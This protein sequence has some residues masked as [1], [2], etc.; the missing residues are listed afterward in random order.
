VPNLLQ[1]YTLVAVAIVLEAH[2]RPNR[3]TTRASALVLC[4]GRPVESDYHVFRMKSASVKLTSLAIPLSPRPTQP[5]DHE[6]H[7]SKNE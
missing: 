7:G 6:A 5:P 3:P 4:W 2:A 1:C